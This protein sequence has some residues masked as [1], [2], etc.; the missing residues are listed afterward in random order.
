MGERKLSDTYKICVD[1]SE[2]GRVSGEGITCAKRLLDKFSDTLVDDPKM[3]RLQRDGK[4]ILVFYVS[5]EENVTVEKLPTT[6]EVAGD[7]ADKE[8]AKKQGFIHEEGG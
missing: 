3:L 4:T 2:V 6:V 7:L 5:A 8:W 1:G